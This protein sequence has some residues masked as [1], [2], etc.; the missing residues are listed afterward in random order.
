M[1]IRF[2]YSLFLIFS[3]VFL[4]CVETHYLA[5]E[6]N[7]RTPKPID[8]PVEIIDAENINTEYKVIG[9]ITIFGDVFSSSQ[10]MR[11]ELFNRAR[12]MGGDAIINFESTPVVYDRYN[13]KGTNKSSNGDV[14]WKGKVIVFE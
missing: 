3:I 14:I 10:E 6:S 9:E 13:K 8:H 5:Y 7:P 4:N 11:K 1:R 12:I 2:I